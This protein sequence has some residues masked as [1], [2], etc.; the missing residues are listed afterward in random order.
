MGN[1]WC[2]GDQGDGQ[3]VGCCEIELEQG[4]FLCMVECFGGDD[5]VGQF[6]ILDQYDEGDDWYDYCEYFEIDW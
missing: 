2:C 5:C 1:E 4:G 6:E 3:Y